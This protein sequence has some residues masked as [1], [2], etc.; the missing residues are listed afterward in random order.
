[1]SKLLNENSNSSVDKV[2]G[3]AVED[4][5]MDSMKKYGN[6]D[7]QFGDDIHASFFHN[8]IHSFLPCVFNTFTT[9]KL[10]SFFK[11]F[12]LVRETIHRDVSL[13]NTTTMR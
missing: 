8:F 13:T 5:L 12:Q 3:L 7:E 1:M 2:M 11:Y 4:L 6:T 9:G 10:L